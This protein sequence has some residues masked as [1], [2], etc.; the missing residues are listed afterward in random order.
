VNV[1]ELMENKINCQKCRFFYITWD[2]K[3]PKGC[4]QFG[5]KTSK[6]PSALV[7]ESSGQPCFH[8]EEKTKKE[9]ER[10]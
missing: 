9:N 10:R 2:R 3:F 6:M 5:F 1:G 4:K 7:K 8:F